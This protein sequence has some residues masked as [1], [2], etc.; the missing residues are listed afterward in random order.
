MK[1]SSTVQAGPVMSDDQAAHLAA[2]T[3]A[4]AED[5]EQ[6]QATEEAQAQDFTVA[7][8]DEIA[9]I[10]GALLAALSPAFPSLKTIYTEQT[11]KAAA[12]ALA[13]VCQKHG[14]LQGGLMGEYAEEITA[15]MICGPLALATARG[16]KADIAAMKKDAKP[17][18]A[19]ALAMPEDRTSTEPADKLPPL[20]LRAG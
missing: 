17:E 16:I 5:G 12:G 1:P 18:A 20:D 2:L 8:S 9:G 19:P 7:L 15:L 6:Q 3:A 13:A 10:A 11:T 14:W 4:A